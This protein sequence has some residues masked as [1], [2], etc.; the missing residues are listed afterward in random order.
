MS[1]IRQ[2]AGTITGGVASYMSGDPSYLMMG[3]GMDVNTHN[4]YKLAKMSLPQ[5]NTPQITN[6]NN[7]NNN[8][9]S[10]RLERVNKYRRMMYE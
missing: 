7:N 1:S 3:A 8:S 9:L 5:Q 2:V 6:N 4:Q 10:N